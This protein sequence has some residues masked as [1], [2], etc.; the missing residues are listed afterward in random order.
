MDVRRKALI[1]AEA[2]QLLGLMTI[3]ID[4]DTMKLKLLKN[5]EVEQP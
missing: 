1:S 5:S 3:H 2:S 4:D